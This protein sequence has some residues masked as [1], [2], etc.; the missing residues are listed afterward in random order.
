MSYGIVI[1]NLSGKL[2]LNSERVTPWLL[3]KGSLTSSG[4]TNS[5]DASSNRITPFLYSVPGSGERLVAITLPTHSSL[6][7]YT[8]PLILD[9]D[10][11]IEL[12][13][14]HDVSQTPTAPEVYI[15]S[16]SAISTSNNNYGLKIMNQSN[17]VMF[18]SSIKPFMPIEVLSRSDGRFS[19]SYSLTNMASK[20]AFLLPYYGSVEASAGSDTLQDGTIEYYTDFFSFFPYYARSGSTLYYESKS[21]LFNRVYNTQQT[22][23]YEL[24][25]IENA[26]I[27]HINAT[28]LD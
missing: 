12:T 5:F 20:P 27:V 11:S 6:V 14:F 28:P 22:D 7:W 13:A 15:F 24:G 10:S 3:G 19:S 1:E 16:T 17:Q 4:P 25:S 21:T 23:F 8:A 9:T 2:V 26:A 18:N